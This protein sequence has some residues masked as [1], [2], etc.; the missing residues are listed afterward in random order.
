MTLT[1]LT[2][3]YNRKWGVERL[4][5]SLRKQTRKDFEWLIVDDGSTDDIGSSIP[6][7]MSEAD[8]PVHFI[9]KENG[10]K[11]TALNAGIVSIDTPLTFI[12]DSDDTLTEDA[13]EI[14]LKYHQKYKS[15]QG[16]CGYSFL[17]IFPDGKINGKLFEPD[18]KVGSYID[19]RINGDDTHADKAEVFY[20]RCLKEFPFP[21]Y[22]GEKF[23]GE[24]VVWVPMGR[25]YSMVHINR[26]ICQSEY[27]DDGLTKNRR[28]NNIAS[29]RGCMHRAAMY[30]E[31]DIKLR[32]RIKGA[33]QFS[34]YGQFV[35]YKLGSL[36]N[37]TE[38]KMLVTMFYPMAAVLYLKWKRA[39][40]ISN[41][42]LGSAQER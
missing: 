23:L 20:T 7:I 36:L 30:M 16:L 26:A 2:P 24:D 27:L 29:P 18:E 21:E 35:G 11:H 4:F 40:M 41:S 38:H 10:G 32:Y 12:V 31:K 34:V 17:Q 6:K 13:V 25:K 1:I 15:H 42:Q 9:R 14:I 37:M 33:L 19:V 5:A 22:S 39:C 3:V 28:K 8:F